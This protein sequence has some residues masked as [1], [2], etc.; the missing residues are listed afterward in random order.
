MTQLV[1]CLAGLRHHLDHLGQLLRF[2]PLRSF[3]EIVRTIASARAAVFRG[4]VRVAIRDYGNMGSCM[5]TTIDI[6]DELLLAAKR[7]ALE[8][9]CTLRELVSRGLRQE[10]AARGRPRRR[11]AALRLP[12]VPGGLAPGLNLDSRQAMYEF[13]RRTR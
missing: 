1:D 3:L 5:K 11:R 8:S 12:T 2:G 10:L 6:P 9:G 13:L 7:R 4:D